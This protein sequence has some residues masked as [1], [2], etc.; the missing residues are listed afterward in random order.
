MDHFFCAKFGFTENAGTGDS[1]L[2]E[3]ATD[4]FDIEI[5]L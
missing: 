4:I 5:G 3:S 2:G 1:A